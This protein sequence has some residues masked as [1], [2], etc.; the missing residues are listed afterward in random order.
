MRR[1]GR[2]RVDVEIEKGIVEGRDRDGEREEG[3]GQ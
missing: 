2:E 3:E 1:K